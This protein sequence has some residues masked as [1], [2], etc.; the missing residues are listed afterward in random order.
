MHEREDQDIPAC[1]PSL[2]DN[3]DHLHAND[4]AGYFH[5]RT[6][7]HV[8]HSTFEEDFSDKLPASLWSDDIETTPFAEN[9]QAALGQD[10][11]R[12]A[13]SEA[14]NHDDKK[15][16]ALKTIAE[17]Q[18]WA[19][20]K[21]GSRANSMPHE[22][23]TDG[24]DSSR[25]AWQAAMQQQTLLQQ[26]QQKLHQAATLQR[27][28]QD[29]LGGKQLTLIEQQILQQYIRQQQEQRF[30]TAHVSNDIPGASSYHMPTN[31]MRY[32]AYNQEQLARAYQ[33]RLSMAAAAAA[34][35][36]VA[37]NGGM[38]ARINQAN[39]EALLAMQRNQQA[40]MARQN[41]SAPIVDHRYSQHQYPDVSWP[42]QGMQGASMNGYHRG[43]STNGKQHYS[44]PTRAH[45]NEPNPVQHQGTVATA[46]GRPSAAPTRSRE[47]IANPVQT[48]RDIG[49]TLYHLGITVEG[50]VNAGLLGGLSA[51]DVRIV[52]D[53]Y[54]IETETMSSVP[55]VATPN[56]SPSIPFAPR[57]SHVSV[58]QNARLQKPTSGSFSNLSAPTPSSPAWSAGAGSTG[59]LPLDM[60][61]TMQ[62]S[63]KSKGTSVADDD[64]SSDS[65]LD[66]LIE[67]STNTAKSDNTETL[68]IP[69]NT[70][71]FDAAR[72]GFF[73]GVS[74]DREAGDGDVLEEEKTDDSSNLIEDS[75]LLRYLNGLK[76]GTDFS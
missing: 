5:S 28:I 51:S 45:M 7:N 68:H 8:S 72:Y 6:A 32:Q 64:D 25:V 62:K 38:Q 50:A 44:V 2:A 17:L 35:A 13:H 52:L 3:R 61:S 69:E 29:Y 46:A 73:G 76:L 16:A 22:N 60:G 67:S 43:A 57:T 70:S 26:Q 66:Q 53:S 14:L 37:T 30:Q 41:Y 42:R 56:A 11:F 33:E 74:K 9:A 21:N 65:L 15:E 54:R 34:A 23:A 20:R 39:M 58:P 59:S 48:L 1:A 47:G 27:I 63:P 75:G 4:E 71:T 31:H 19:T 18:Q 36:S 10:Y 49:K 55:Q 24:T 40:N 12:S